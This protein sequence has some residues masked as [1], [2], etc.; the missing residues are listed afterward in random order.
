[1]KMPLGDPNCVHWSRNFP[2]WSKIWMRL[3]D[4]SPTSSPAARVEEDR[5]RHVELA[6]AVAFLAPRL[7]E[8][9]VLREFHD[10][11]VDVAVGDE[12]VAVRRDRH[13]RDAVERVGAVARD[14]LV[15]SVI[16]S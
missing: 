15:P 10:A 13:V 5:V 1:M 14:A 4:R 11:R 3:F 6:G 7:D 8:R 9:A 16:T 2:S 12:D